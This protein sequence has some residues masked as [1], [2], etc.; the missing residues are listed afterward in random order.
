MPVVHAATPLLTHL[1]PT[2]LTPSFVAEL[3]EGYN[4]FHRNHSRDDMVWFARDERTLNIHK[5]RVFSK[6]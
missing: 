1:P 3:L 4:C 6:L 5:E 2:L